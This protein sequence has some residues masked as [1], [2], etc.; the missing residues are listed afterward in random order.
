MNNNETSN[1]LQ[2]ILGILSG[3][4]SVKVDVGISLSSIIILLCGIVAVGVLLIFINAKI[5][6]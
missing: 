5:Q 4:E 3:E 1:K 6:K 2:G